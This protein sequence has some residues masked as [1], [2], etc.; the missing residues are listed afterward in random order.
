METIRAIEDSLARTEG[1]SPTSAAMPP[2]QSP[3]VDAAPE[4]TALEEP[5]E[6]SVSMDAEENS[7]AAAT[8]VK[9]ARSIQL[10]WLRSH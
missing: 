6:S 2:L 10:S 3:G 5:A 9:N 7:R 4:A 8:A 1:E